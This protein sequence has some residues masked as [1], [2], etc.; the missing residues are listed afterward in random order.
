MPRHLYLKLIA[1]ASATV[2]AAAGGRQSAGR[3]ARC[4]PWCARR[5][6]ARARRTVGDHQEHRDRP[7]A[8]Q[9]AVRGRP[10][11]RIPGGVVRRGRQVRRDQRRDRLP[12][13]RAGVRSPRTMMIETRDRGRDDPGQ[14]RRA[15]VV[16]GARR[17]STC[18]TNSSGMEPRRSRRLQA[19]PTSGCGPRPR[20]RCCASTA[21][22][23]KP[24]NRR[25]AGGLIARRR[26]VPP[27]IQFGTCPG[28]AVSRDDSP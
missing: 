19:T 7:R 15:V 1:K 9:V 17:S 14:G 25:C 16:D 4:R 20:S 5:R 22:S 3:R 10:A 13:Q 6:G 21:C 28:F 27:V 8:G 23:R 2:R 18:A 11:R 24:A 26:G 12:R